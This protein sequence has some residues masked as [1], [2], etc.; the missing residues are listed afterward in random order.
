MC[1]SS[2]SGRRTEMARRTFTMVDVTEILQ[3]WYAGR[4]KVEVARS[5]GVDA[6]TVRRYVAAAEAAGMAPGG[7]PVTEERWRALARGWFPQ[8]AGT[9]IRQVSWRQIAVHHDRIAELLGV[10]PVSVIHQRLADEQGLEAS[11]ASVRRYVRAHFPDR[12]GLEVR[13]HRPPSAPG[14][15]A[16]VDYG[17]L[18][19]WPD[20]ATGRRRRVW[21]F[22][23]VLPYSR[24]LFVRPVVSMTQRAWTEAH[25]AAF[26]FFGGA[27]RKLTPDYVAR[28]IIRVLCPA[29][30]CARGGD[31]QPGSRR[32]GQARA[33]AVHIT[34]A[35]GEAAFLQ[36]TRREEV[37]MLEEYFVKPD[38]VD[39][40][41]SSWAGPE[42]ER[43]VAWLAGQGYRPRTVWHR[44]PLLL[45][46]AE[47]AR[48]RGA[49]TA[50][51]LPAHVEAFVADCVTRREAC[52]RGGPVRQDPS[53]E[54]RGPV[55]QMLE[56][57]VP[58]YQASGRRHH[59]MPFSGS[60]PGFFEYLS[61][62]RGLR[63]ASILRYQHYLD[64]FEAYLARIGVRELAELSPA[65]LSAFIAERS[66][67][68]LAK[69]TV[70]GTCGARRVFLRYARR[71]G[72][73]RADL[74]A[75]VEWPQVYRLS[76]IPRSIS[77]AQVGQVLDGVDRR[78]PAGKR[79][80]A[81][82]LLLVTYGL[83]AREVAA[84]TLDDIDWRRERL[85]V[86]ERKAGH[87]TAF[88]LAVSVGAALADYLQHGRPQTAGRQVFF[89]TAA[90]VRPV[91]AAAVSAV[92]RRYLLQA[93]IDVPRPGSHTLRHTA[94]Q[95][96]VD[97]GFPLKTIGDYI[98]HRSPRSTEVYAN[99]RELHQMNA[100]AQV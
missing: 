82:L 11:V 79:D 41:R 38:T 25:V 5:L 8:I 81:M 75:A 57:V 71:Q 33:R 32:D 83:R 55:E 49:R 28:N 10:V 59:D 73:I 31:D 9:G 69:T 62:A 3:H 68:G 97:A 74:S 80:Y 78:T 98:G 99:S 23:M 36:L 6:K 53:K 94:V 66:G 51:D 52:R 43:Y 2:A 100:F 90:P 35:A 7:P 27:P 13:M 84:L 29:A 72:H 58:G 61:D 96:L 46:F 87:S 37:A 64:R 50:E 48:D 85:A 63:P 95:Q 21:A 18:G 86:P 24:H 26:G 76:D 40:I 93:G 30:L 65:I 89:R 70:G 54:F 17:Y 77:W 4:P 88:P 1:L 42:V 45:G 67:A 47:F 15:E 20:P 92:A 39:R 34:L 91:G 22:S 19:L 12:R 44:V 60:V 16:Q 56:L 14:A